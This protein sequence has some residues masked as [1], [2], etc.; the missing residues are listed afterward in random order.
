MRDRE[1]D[2]MNTAFIDLICCALGSLLMLMLF[3]ACLARAKA[4]RS[5]RM[6]VP[7]LDRQA[8]LDWG[9]EG[10]EAA[11]PDPLIVVLEWDRPAKYPPR[12]IA[13]R[14][15]IR[16]SVVVGHEGAGGRIECSGA[17]SELNR[18]HAPV[19]RWADLATDQGGQFN[20]STR[21]RP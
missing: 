18:D 14:S 6:S 1:I 5:V 17:P 3:V 10:Y 2:T 16:G 9:D 11:P 8:G 20:A 4:D 7:G 15:G 13:R 21:R 12:V 19:L